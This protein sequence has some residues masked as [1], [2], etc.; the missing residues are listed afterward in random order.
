MPEDIVRFSTLH[1]QENYWCYV[2]ERLVHYYK[3]QTTN[4][5]SM[6]KIFADRANQMFFITLYLEI[7]EQFG[8]KE[9]ETASVPQLFLHSSTYSEA[10]ALKEYMTYDSDSLTQNTHAQLNDGIVIGKE[11][12]F[13]LDTQQIADIE[14]WITTNN[15]SLDIPM[16]DMQM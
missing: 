11:S 3:M 16:E 10:I 8:A 5:K 14:Y 4:N 6:C 1:D 7:N 15:P 9:K 13:L 2:F 12:I